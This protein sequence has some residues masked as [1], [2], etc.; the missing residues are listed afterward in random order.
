MFKLSWA[1]VLLPEAILPV[2][3]LVALLVAV[4]TS[5]FVAL[6]VAV[7]AAVPVAV[8]VPG[9]VH[10][11][12]PEEEVEGSQRREAHGAHGAALGPMSH[13]DTKA[14]AVSIETNL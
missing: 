6:L 8:H 10:R 11:L 5:P 7:P 4:L 12:R 1:V 3:V 13:I 9:N 14:D 2:A